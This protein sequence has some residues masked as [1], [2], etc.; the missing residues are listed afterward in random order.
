MYKIYAHTGSI[1]AFCCSSLVD[2][3]LQELH[4]PKRK[5]DIHHQWLK[6]LLVE[7]AE[8]FG[9]VSSLLEKNVDSCTYGLPGF[10]ECSFGDM[11]ELHMKCKASCSDQ[12]VFKSPGEAAYARKAHSEVLRWTNTLPNHIQNLMM[13]KFRRYV[14]QKVSVLLFEPETGYIV[15]SIVTKKLLL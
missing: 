7:Y 3:H 14:V 4:N 2:K 6:D 13:K 11:W 5:C 15:Q 1:H 10:E 12:S 8:S 9:P